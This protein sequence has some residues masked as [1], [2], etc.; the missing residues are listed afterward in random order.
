MPG[1]VSVWGSVRPKV[2][3]TGSTGLSGRVSASAPWSFDV[4]SGSA[5]LGVASLGACTLEL[6]S[7]D[8]VCTVPEEFDP[9]VESGP[10]F[11]TGAGAVEVSVVGSEVAEV[12]VPEG[13]VVGASVALTSSVAPGVGAHVPLVSATLAEE[14]VVVVVEV[15]VAS[16][17]EAHPLVVSGAPAE[18]SVV[19][20]EVSVASGA[21]AGASL[22]PAVLEV[23]VVPEASV[24]SAAGADASLVSAVLEVSVVPEASVASAAGADASLVSVVLELSGVVAEVS[25]GDD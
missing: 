7:E 1:K 2:V 15:S 24:A 5:S 21:A 25:D 19:V 12:S 16:G 9:E 20:A 3:A 17:A 18:A 14:S 22:V 10:G 8:G 4:D 11:V 13:S 6:G 23:S